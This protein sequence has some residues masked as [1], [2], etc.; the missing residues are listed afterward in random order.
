MTLEADL[1]FLNQANLRVADHADISKL[2]DT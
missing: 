2:V 1:P